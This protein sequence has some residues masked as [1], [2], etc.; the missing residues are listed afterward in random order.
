MTAVE[1]EFAGDELVAVEIDT[2]T[3]EVAE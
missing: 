3:L 1:L 2:E